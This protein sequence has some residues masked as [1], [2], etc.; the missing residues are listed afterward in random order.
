MVSVQAFAKDNNIHMNAAYWKGGDAFDVVVKETP[1]LKM[2]LYVND[3][4][5]T[6]AIVNSEGWATFKGVRLSGNGKIS[7]TWVDN[8]DQEHPINYT[9]SY[10][11]SD[12]RATLADNEPTPEPKAPTAAPTLQPNTATPPASTAAPAAVYY[13]NCTEARAAGV[14]PIHS[15]QP[16]YAAHLDR[17]GD[18]IACE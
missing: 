12:P 17:D 2:K 18:G 7:F 16:G 11:I 9:S 8:S 6:E 15:G 4:N 3:K 13:K 5:S 14:T 10:K 1:N